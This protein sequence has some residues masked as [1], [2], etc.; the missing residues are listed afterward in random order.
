MPSPVGTAHRGRGRPG[1]GFKDS[2][3]DRFGLRMVR[4]DQYERHLRSIRSTDRYVLA[5][6]AKVA[7]SNRVSAWP[8][9]LP[10]QDLGRRW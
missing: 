10:L 4:P 7:G 9:C 2:V 6:G 3:T 1:H 5:D 8:L